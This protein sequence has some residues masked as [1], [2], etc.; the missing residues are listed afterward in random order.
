M[1]TNKFLLLLATLFLTTVG[2]VAQQGTPTE[3]SASKV[4]QHVSYLASDALDGRRTGTQGA[5]D[6]ARYVAGEFS[7]LGL[8]P[9]FQKAGASRKPSLAMSQYLQQFPYVAGVELGKGNKM[10]VFRAPSPHEFTV[11][12]D[13]MPLAFST[14]A[15]VKASMQFVGFGLTASEQNYDDYKDLDLKGRIAVALQGTPDGDNPH[16]QFARYDGI[17]WKAIAARN[18]GAAALFVVAREKNFKDEKFATLL[19][20]NSAGDAGLPV[21]VISRDA[22]NRLLGTPSVSYLEEIAKTKTQAT[23]NILVGETFLSTDVV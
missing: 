10:I 14:N 12:D 21:V 8:R 7:R 15:L 9:A 11:G 5:N 2:V 1:K 18:A 16:G 20:D 3:P 6:A 23:R 19:Y 4:Q 13:W 22:V 17:R